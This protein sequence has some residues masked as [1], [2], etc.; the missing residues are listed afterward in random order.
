[1]LDLA[2][3]AVL[4]RAVPASQEA[5]EALA[6]SPLPSR[7]VPVPLAPSWP[8]QRPTDPPPPRVLA[9]LPSEATVRAGH[10][11]KSGELRLWLL[12]HRLTVDVARERRYEAVPRQVVWHCPAI[13][14][15][16]ALGITDRHLRNLAKG[17]ERAGLLDYGGHAQQVGSRS[18]YDGTIWAVLTQSGEPP[19]IQADDWRHTWRPDF[20]ADVVGKTGAAATCSELLQAQAGP[21]DYYAE[22]KHRAA[23]P[24]ASR[25][26]LSSSPEVKPRSTLRDV[27]EGLAGLWRLHSS[28]RARAVGVL[29]SQL[30]GALSEPDRRR[31]WC[32]VFW[33]ALTAQ[34]EGRGGL[35]VLGAQLERLAADLVE[36]APWRSP[37]AV[38]A[39]RLK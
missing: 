9:S 1:M 27:I 11:L 16:A 25:G 13:T 33:Q 20:E 18:M 29:A 17:L 4:A 10:E 32:G 22:A 24:A 26:P 30:A 28:K 23:V 39:A 19:R 36:G 5:S 38:L 21:E 35:Q 34:D 7:P 6:A 2:R 31:Y 12:L 15:A 14:L 3:A 37:G 8:A